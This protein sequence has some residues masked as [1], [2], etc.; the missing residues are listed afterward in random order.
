MVA[1][2]SLAK[3]VGGEIAGPGDIEISGINDL[4]NASS[5]QLSFISI[6]ATTKFFKKVMPV[7]SWCP[8]PLKAT[9]P[10]SF[11]AATPT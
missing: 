8:R 2:S 11:A 7:R 4:A 3:L 5:S 6:A 1:L 10:I 9:R